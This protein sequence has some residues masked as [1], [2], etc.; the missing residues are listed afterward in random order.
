MVA[1]VFRCVPHLEQHRVRVRLE[2]ELDLASARIAA[3]RIAELLDDGV[4][5]IVIDLSGLQ[6]IDPSGLHLVHELADRLGP[7]CAGIPGP[8]AVQRLFRLMGL[9]AIIPFVDAP[10]PD[11]PPRSAGALSDV[12]RRPQAVRRLDS[13]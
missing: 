12:G 8:P 7:R 5:T 3:A 4:E 10:A 13:A 9:E 6:F 11:P 1:S 2:G